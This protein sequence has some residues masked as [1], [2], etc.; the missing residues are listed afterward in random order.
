[1]V[2]QQQFMK[3]REDGHVWSLV[4]LYSSYLAVALFAW[5]RWKILVSSWQ[6]SNWD[7]FYLRE[8]KAEAFYLTPFMETLSI[9]VAVVLVIP[10]AGSWCDCLLGHQVQGSSGLGAQQATGDWRDWGSPTPSQWGPYEGES[11]QSEHTHTHKARHRP[12]P[13][14]Y[15]EYW[16]LVSYLSRL[17]TV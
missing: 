7:H 15:G 4:N 9:P 14:R 11:P 13:K 17:Y 8:K 3:G 2:I 6:L 16:L 12:H 10:H 5:Q 1:M